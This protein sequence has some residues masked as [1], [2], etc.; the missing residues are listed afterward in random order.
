MVNNRTL[1]DLKF[2]EIKLGQVTYVKESDVIF[3]VCAL[4]P[5]FPGSDTPRES[6]ISLLSE[7]GTISHILHTWGDNQILLENIIPEERWLQ[8]LKELAKIRKSL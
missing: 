3:V 1:A 2:S 7:N 8:Y 6:T 4:N 5:E